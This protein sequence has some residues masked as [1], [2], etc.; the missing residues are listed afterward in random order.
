MAEEL[1]PLYL[2]AG[3]DGAKIDATRARLKARAE[4]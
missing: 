1:S 4:T 2:I 3:T